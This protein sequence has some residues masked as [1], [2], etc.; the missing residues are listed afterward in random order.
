MAYP[1]VCEPCL[2][3]RHE[4]CEERKPVPRGLIGGGFCVCSHEKEP[5]SEFERYVRERDLETY[6]NRS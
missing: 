4:Q 5:D 1:Y 2:D 3:G 6:R